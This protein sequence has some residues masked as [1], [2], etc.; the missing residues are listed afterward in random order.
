LRGKNASARV[1]SQLLGREGVYFY[2]QPQGTRGRRNGYTQGKGGGKVLAHDLKKRGA[3]LPDHFEVIKTAGG[4]F[5][6][7]PKRGRTGT[8]KGYEVM[9][10]GGGGRKVSSWNR[11]SERDFVREVKELQ[12]GEKKHL[13][14]GGGATVKVRLSQSVL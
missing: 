12:R 11:P 8:R 4:T 2:L 1:D 10:A 5:V 14:R 7:P 13:R 6:L 3:N 9:D